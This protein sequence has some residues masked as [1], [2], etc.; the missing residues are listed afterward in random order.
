M[1]NNKK[2]LVIAPIFNKYEK[3][4]IKTLEESSLY[5][6]IDFIPDCP[7]FNVS[8]YYYII[9]IFP[10]L[11]SYLY[12]RYNKRIS[13]L[14]NKEQYN[15]IFIIKGQF[16]DSK[17]LKSIKDNRSSTKIITYQWDSIQNNMNAVNLIKF[18]DDS[19]TFDPKDSSDLKIN[20]LPLFSCWNEAQLDIDLKYDIK[21]DFVSVGG[22]RKHRMNYI[23]RFKE[24]CGNN[25]YSYLF[26]NYMRFGAFIK[27]RKK[28]N[29]K[30]E[31]VNFNKIKY[32]D[33]LKILLSSRAV[34]DI[35]SPNQKGLTMRTME[36]L[37]LSKK[38]I[39]SNSQILQEQFYSPNNILVVEDVN[40]I[41]IKILHQFM[42]RPFINDK[43][44]LTLTNWLTRMSLLW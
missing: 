39:T 14:V 7:L 11:K 20:Y 27:N 15:T 22:F 19:Y 34:I 35:P 3:Y 21:Y 16:V 31:D 29:I 2:L 8:L 17:I 33:Y 4:I 6:K 12:R 13:C 40:D 38:L 30:F 36:T 23:N 44:I 42:S 9:N 18:S 41:D 25:G 10:F 37:S 24:I 32:S 26:H 28:L 1:N 5:A 43:K